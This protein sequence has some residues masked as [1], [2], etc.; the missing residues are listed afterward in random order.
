MG[1]QDTVVCF[2]NQVKMFS[3][4][5]SKIFTVEKA[6]LKCCKLKCY[7]LF[8]VSVLVYDVPCCVSVIGLCFG[9]HVNVVSVEKLSSFLCLL[10]G[11]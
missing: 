9:G 6:E 8:S 4:L 1:R 11:R 10:F 3:S 5:W 2:C 7:K